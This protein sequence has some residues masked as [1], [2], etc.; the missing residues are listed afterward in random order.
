MKY[1]LPQQHLEALQPKVKVKCESCGVLLEVVVPQNYPNPTM[2]VRC[3]NCSSLLEVLLKNAQHPQLQSGAYG[4]P[5]GLQGMGGMG[6]LENM[7]YLQQ[8]K[9]PLQRYD[10]SMAALSS[11]GQ[12]Q[13]PGGGGLSPSPGPSMPFSQYN[14]LHHPHISFDNMRGPGT[15]I[16]EMQRHQNIQMLMNYTGLQSGHKR[17]LYD[18]PTG[19][20]LHHLQHGGV[21][22]GGGKPK[23][24]KKDPSRPKKLSLYNKYVSQEVHRLKK[25][26]QKFSYKDMFKIAAASWKTSPMNPKFM[27]AKNKVLELSLKTS[28]E[29][30]EDSFIA[31]ELKYVDVVAAIDNNH[32][33]AS[34]DPQP[35]PPAL[36]PAPA[37][38]SPTHAH[39]KEL[40][41][42]EEEEIKE[43]EGE[44]KK[45]LETISMDVPGTQDKD[46]MD[47][48]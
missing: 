13:Q 48:V 29:E 43:A 34:A 35:T 23:R 44:M 4:L 6:Q 28:L 26:D 36:E 17:G 19:M 45:S 37:P 46:R 9:N 24:R 2:I 30:D 42:V 39:N 22:G 33:E 32:Q 7:S 27:G 21:G 15:D 10:M 12:M 38:V 31:V 47:V 16:Q 25:S 8:S 3:G 1:N 41:N 14:M 20:G 40:P 5:G 11:L 18:D